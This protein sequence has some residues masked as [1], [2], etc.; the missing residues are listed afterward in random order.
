MIEF[1][2]ALQLLS[3]EMPTHPT[4]FVSYSWDDD[5][6]KGWVRELAAR[7]RGDAVDVRLDQWHSVPGNQ[8][9]H[10]MESEISRNDFVIIVCTPKYK[11]K[12]DGRSGGVGYEGDIMTAE[13]LTKQNHL[14][15]IPVLAR[16]TWT[17]AAPNWLVGKHYI[18]MS[19]SSSYEVG[20]KELRDT[21][22]G[23]LPEVP[24][25]GPLPAGYRSSSSGNQWQES[26]LERANNFYHYAIG[27]FS[28]VIQEEQH[29]ITGLG[30]LDIVLVFNG[31]SNRKWYN[32]DRFISALV[33]AYP[34]PIPSPS[35]I[36]RTYQGDDSKLRPY[37]IGDTYEQLFL[38][39]A[40]AVS[41]SGLR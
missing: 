38:S 39:D 13:V 24:T 40:T 8:L 12:S 9:P 35:Y 2:V 28:T 34:N 7:L 3:I 41:F 29:D 37:T 26:S 6:H 23:M 25:L 19:G 36:F 16:G 11:V 22:L 21:L 27:R 4:A 30:F 20:Y 31:T 17:E 33:A 5:T 14:K 15:F 1:P 32:D 18:D 10:F